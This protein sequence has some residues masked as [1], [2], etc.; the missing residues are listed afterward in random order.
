MSAA[1]S[2]APQVQVSQQPSRR[3]WVALA[4]I[5]LAQLMIALDATIVSIALPSAQAALGASDADRQWVVTAYTLA[6]GGLLLLGGRVADTLGRKR[7]FVIGLAGFALASVIG[8]AAPN[9]GVLVAARAMQGAFAALLAPT[10][11]SLLAISFTQPRER[12]T[13]FAVY[14]SIAGSGAAIGMLLGGALT[15][16]L[17]W[18]WCLYVNLPIAVAAAIG[19]WSVVPDSTSRARSSF[20]V[21]GAV[22]VTGGLVALVYACTEAATSGWSSGIAVG[23][24]VISAAMLVLFVV[25]EARTANP[26]LPLRI[27]ADRNRGG[28]YVTVGLGVAGMFG[29]FLFLTYYMQVVLHYTPLQAGLAFLPI[30]IASQAGSWLIARRLLPR[31]APRTFM[32]PAA[33][34]AAAGMALLTQMQVGSG[35]LSLILPAEILLGLGISSLMVPAFSLATLGV[36]QREAGVAS[37]TVNTAQQIGASLGTAVLNTI[38]AGATAGFA[39]PRLAALV[40]GFAVATGWGAVVLVLAAITSGVLITAGPLKR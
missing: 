37:A 24:L 9:F 8:G 32:V 31:L 5:A 28:A 25:R 15:Q 19:G 35:Y 18:R 2:L 3:R 27:L 16:Y 20:D 36:D 38:A 22:L 17:S 26:L 21:P 34:V 10:A 6:F 13:A 1:P 40:H 12:A 4:F 7:A 29:A 23:L 11:L 30:T 14:G 33:L 39:G